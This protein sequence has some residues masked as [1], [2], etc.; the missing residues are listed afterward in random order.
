M[1]R[2]R[3][4]DKRLCPFDLLVEVAGKL[5][6]ESENSTFSPSCING[7]SKEVVKQDLLCNKEDLKTEIPDLSSN[8][9]LSPEI[10]IKKQ[11]TAS[12]ELPQSSKLEHSEPLCLQM[13]SK[14]ND[15]A[16]G[17]S[18]VSNS[19]ISVGCSAYT[20]ICRSVSI[21]KSSAIAEVGGEKDELT[22]VV[23]YE[24]QMPG[25][26]LE[27]NS[28]DMY[29]LEDP[30]DL[31]VKPPAPASSD[32]SAEVPVCRD[33]P[34]SSSMPKHESGIEHIVHRDDDDNSSGCT[35][36]NTITN[37]A[38]R[39]T[40][41]TGDHGERKF[42]TSKYWKAAINMSK[43]GQI[44]HHGMHS[45]LVSLFGNAKLILIQVYK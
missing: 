25:N 1:A 14:I 43:Y 6:S 17:G 42:S 11:V 35:H 24:D 12:N 44:S 21:R 30:M 40:N 45:Y 39:P 37:K 4:D 10:A 19:G 3:G 41:C 27:L 5:S 38:S 26:R 7:R 9:I 29:S 18:V 20:D 28:M 34:C 32:S 36:P 23:K 15:T 13:K 8:T 22:R 31:D 2:K 16:A 33:N